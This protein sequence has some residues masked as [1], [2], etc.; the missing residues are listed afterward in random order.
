MDEDNRSEDLVQF[1]LGRER[2]EGGCRRVGIVLNP[3][4]L[5]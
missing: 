5:V 2:L 3:R 1:R 4:T